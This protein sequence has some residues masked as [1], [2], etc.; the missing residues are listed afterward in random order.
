M[1]SNYL[2][3]CADVGINLSKYQKSLLIQ[4]EQLPYENNPS[5]KEIMAAL[6]TMLNHTLFIIFH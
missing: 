6:L 2:L 4:R 5:C 3:N 1:V